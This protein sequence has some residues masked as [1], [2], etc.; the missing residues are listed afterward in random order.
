MRILNS[1]IALALIIGLSFSAMVITATGAEANRSVI[2]F[3]YKDQCKNI[4][5]KQTVNMIVGTGKF[6]LDMSTK[7]KRDCYRR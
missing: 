1:A 2:G 5:G 4:K 6:R 7:R 3:K